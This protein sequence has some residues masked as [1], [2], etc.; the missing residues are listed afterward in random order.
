MAAIVA[1]AACAPSAGADTLFVEGRM[2]ARVTVE[3]V[4]RYDPA[5]G[6]E[7]ITIRS[8]RTP[9]FDSATWRQRVVTDDVTYST[10][11]VRSETRA[12][13]NAELTERWPRPSAPIQIVR[14]IVVE[15]EGTLAPVQSQ[16]AFPLAA[17]P[18][19]AQRFLRG[20]PLTQRE[21]P[22]IRELAQRLTAG[23]RTEHEAVSRLLGHVVD[24]LHYHYDAAAHDAVTALARGIANCQGYSHLSVAL[25]RAAG[26]PARLVVGLSL[27][28]AWR[29]TS[30]D[31]TITFRMGKGRHAWIEVYYPDLGWVPY[32][33]QT[34][35]LFVSLYHVRQAV[36]LDVREA[37]GLIRAAPVLPRMNE[38]LD[39]DGAH[40][41]FALTTTS[42]VRAPRNFVISAA[43]RDAA[44]AVTPPPAPVTPPPPVTPP[45]PPDRRSLTRPTEFG[46]TDF[47]AALRIFSA[48]P[49]AAAAVAEASHT[50]VVETA[51]YATGPD[52]LAQ[53]FRVDEPLLLTDVAL[54]LQK[55]GGRTG[56]LWL[57][58]HAD[59]ARTPG[60]KVAETRR[61]PVAG[62][63]DRG[64][65]RWV[66]FR[67]G[68]D[69]Q[70]P[71]LAPGR[72]WAVLRWNGD[73]IF[74]WYFSLGNAYGDPDDTRSRPRGASTWSNILN[75][76]FNFRISG[77]VTP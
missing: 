46:N 18:P 72:Y 34:S 56:E 71:V 25:L 29:V 75:Y 58:L 52:E 68:P 38:T 70:E 33:A 77:L 2:A 47:P 54:A 1:V 27:S 53:A 11:P 60:A 32:D 23:A 15:T 51:E 48:V 45:A 50:F 28:K 5:P 4:E 22:A 31:G 9:S 74:N 21:D 66:V 43:V 67:F 63:L 73:G 61:V 44:V 37:T 19:D 35:H 59:H 65:Y 12:G 55:F 30:A 64:G 26:I 76:R 57:E 42:Q 10:P 8:F 39:G 13:D 17:L 16:A 69:G 41:T 36:G 14:K 6:T 20:T 40:E 7:W 62:L 3:L 49:G 24:A